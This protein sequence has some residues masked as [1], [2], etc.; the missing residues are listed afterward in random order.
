MNEEILTV[1]PLLEPE[2]G[3][4]EVIDSEE[5]LKKA[6]AELSAGTGA[7]AVDAERAS[8]YK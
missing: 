1:T 8:G 3:T 6:I 2:A 4:P 5:A 7:F